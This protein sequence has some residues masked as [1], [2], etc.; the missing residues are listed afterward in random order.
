MADD[1]TVLDAM[2]VLVRYVLRD[3]RGV[4]V[5]IVTKY[6]AQRRT[7]DVQPVRR[8]R[9]RGTVY[10][11]APVVDAPVGTWRLGG[12]VLAGELE[13]GDEVL[14]V[15]CEREI[16]PWWLGGKAHDPQSRRMHAPEDSVVLPWISNVTRAITAQAPGTLY[17]GRE[18]GTAG[19]TITRGPAPGRT[20]VEGTGPG[21]IQ[22]GATAVSPALMGTEALVALNGYTGAVT[23]AVVALN[24]ASQTYFGIPLP[25][26]PQQATYQAA[27]AAFNAA[28]G[29]AQT[30]LSSALTAALA[31]K[32]VVE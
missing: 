25:T 9:V 4:R 15:T 19:I 24:T 5:G 31:T 16:R 26:P 10:D 6:D 14:L 20:T 23:G 17:L 30:A 18:D 11:E 32:T 27:W 28:V 22:L 12:M 21:S 7:A 29:G 2:S 8:R 13:V 3:H 1:P